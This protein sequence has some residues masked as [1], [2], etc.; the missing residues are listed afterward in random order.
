MQ[1]KQ[2]LILANSEN[3]NINN[4][5]D[6]FNNFYYTNKEN[7]IMIDINNKYIKQ[8]LKKNDEIIYIINNHYKLD[9][10]KT[11]NIKKIKLDIINY[12]DLVD[13]NKSKKITLTKLNNKCKK[14]I[15]IYNKKDNEYISQE[16][17]NY[18][19]QNIEIEDNLNNIFKLINNINNVK[20]Y[21]L[22]TY[23]NLNIYT[24]NNKEYEEFLNN[25]EKVNKEVYVLY[26][27]INNKKNN[28]SY[29]KYIINGLQ[30]LINIKRKQIFI[31]V[32]E[33]NYFISNFDY[34]KNDYKCINKLITYN[35]DNIYIN[36]SNILNNDNI[37]NINKLIFIYNCFNIY[38]KNKIL[39]L[40]NN[41]KVI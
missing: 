23:D 25:I 7:N 13:I 24:L 34:S 14:K 38:S 6:E 30:E 37:N 12:K 41:Y 26:E 16:Y 4:D 20:T 31:E 2:K 40:S 36:L 29:R 15:N 10:I 3:I 18:I 33:K 19:M 5:L 27:K 17:L 1:T 39:Y 22:E 9:K 28:K 21:I 32:Y 35:I 8:K 11:I